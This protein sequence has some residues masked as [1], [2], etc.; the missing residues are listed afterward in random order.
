MRHLF[1]AL[2]LIISISTNAQTEKDS[3]TVDEGVTSIMMVT[4]EFDHYDVLEELIETMRVHEAFMDMKRSQMV[5]TP[6]GPSQDYK[7]I[8]EVRFKSLALT[9]DWRQK[10]ESQIPGERRALL[11]GVKVYFYQYK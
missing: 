2:L 6:F 4:N 1:T 10:M 8:I 9:S 7:E 3:T 5:M 11:A